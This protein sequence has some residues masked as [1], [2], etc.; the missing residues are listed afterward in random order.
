MSEKYKSIKEKRTCVRLISIVET[1]GM[2][3]INQHHK[4]NKDFGENMIYVFLQ[5]YKKKFHFSSMDLD[6]LNFIL[7]LLNNVNQNQ[8]DA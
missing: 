3:F 4:Q 1:F 6:Y 7:I 2:Y 5:D 8:T